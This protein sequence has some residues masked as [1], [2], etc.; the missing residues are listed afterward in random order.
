M[1]TIAAISTAAGSA[2]RAIVRLSGPAAME[3]AAA[4]SSRCKAIRRTARASAP[5]G[6]GQFRLA[7]G[8]VELP[9]RAYVFR[10]PRSYTARTC[11]SCTSPA[12]LWR[13]P[14][15]WPQFWRPGRAK[16]RPASSTSRAFFSGRIDLSA[17]EGVADVI[18]AA[19]ESQLRAA[20][21]AVEGRTWRFCR[22]AGE[23]LTDVLATVEA[24]I[25]LADE[26]VELESPPGLAARLMD[27]A[28]RLR[29]FAAS[30]A[31][32]PDA[33]EAPRVVIVGRPNAGKSS[34]LNALSGTDRAIVSAM[35]GT[36]RD[37]LSAPMSLAAPR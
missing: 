24:S 5:G 19:D 16:P 30:A 29:R 2:E 14:R 9:A 4:Y 26:R 11:A 28:A 18:H 23:T 8:H 32:L 27:L 20:A 31:D 37:V 25:E 13:R 12:P 10:A 7:G 22:A 35:A 6:A 1:T 34:L 36:T 17:A 3:I 21:A 33:A 15:Y